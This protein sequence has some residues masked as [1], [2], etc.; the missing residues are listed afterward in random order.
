MLEDIDK[1]GK[2]LRQRKRIETEYGEKGKRL[3]SLKTIS[4]KS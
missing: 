4:M 1:N 2:K 3:F